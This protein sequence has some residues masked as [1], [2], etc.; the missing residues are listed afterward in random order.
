MA[1]FLK[2]H[3]CLR[4]TG[5]SSYSL[6]SWKRNR[7]HTQIIHTPSHSLHTILYRTH[8]RTHVCLHAGSHACLNTLPPSLT[9]IFSH[10][11]LICGI[12]CLYCGKCFSFKHARPHNAGSKFLFGGKCKMDYLIISEDKSNALIFLKTTCAA[13][14]CQTQKFLFMCSEWNVHIHGGIMLHWE[15]LVVLKLPVG[16]QRQRHGLSECMPFGELSGVNHEPNI[17]VFITT[18]VR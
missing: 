9:H 16:V 15:F 13:N 3:W 5:G 6:M 1:V 8:T 7:A 10:N 2:K 11:I 14:F 18:N 4:K 12:L 17:K